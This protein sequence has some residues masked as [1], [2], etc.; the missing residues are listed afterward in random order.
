MT[1]IWREE[2]ADVRDELEPRRGRV[3]V[4][5]AED[6]AEARLAM[7]RA[8]RADG[9][10]VDEIADGRELDLRLLLDSMGRGRLPDIIVTN[11]AMPG[12]SGLRVIEGI[13]ERGWST[14]VVFLTA[15][16][17]HAVLSRA[18]ALEH[19]TLVDKPLDVEVFR[20]AV[21]RAPLT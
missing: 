6:D 4:L 19:V 14:P 1:T 8:L 21:R 7:A 13:R 16:R 18:R 9:Y 12:R 17:D 11:M 20:K 15:S 10:H 3:R 2:R 5:V